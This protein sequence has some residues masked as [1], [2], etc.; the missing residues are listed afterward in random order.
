MIFHSERIPASRDKAGCILQKDVNLALV[1]M[2]GLDNFH[3][4]SITASIFR[5]SAHYMGY[6]PV[7]KYV[8]RMIKLRWKVL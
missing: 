7:I 2:D 5:R 8:D 1:M 4:S 6:I 3:P